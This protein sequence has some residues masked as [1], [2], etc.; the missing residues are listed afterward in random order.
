MLTTLKTYKRLLVFAKPYKTR[1]IIGIVCGILAGG[2]LFGA[3]RFI[4]PVFKPFEKEV[5][6][7]T[8]VQTEEGATEEEEDSFLDS[9]VDT[10]AAKFNIEKAKEDGT[11]TWQFMLLSILGLPL[12]IG[13]R[14]VMTFLNRY[15]MRW[16][17][18]RIIMDIR[19]KLFENLGR[20]SLKYFSL[21]DV[22]GLISRCTYD[23]QMVEGAVSRSIADLTRAPIEIFAAAL[24]IVVTAIQYGI[25]G[26]LFVFLIL[27]P[28]ILLP[29][30]VLSRRIKRHTSLALQGISRLVSRMQETFTGIK[31]IKAFNTEKTELERFK[32]LNFN[33][34]KDMIRALRAELF[35]QPWSEVIG[36]V[37]A[38]LGLVYCF[39]KDINLYQVAPLA[40]AVLFA[41]RPFKQLIK[42]NATVQRSAAAAERLYEILDAD[43]SLPEPK[44]AVDK[45]SFDDKI[46]FDNVSFRYSSSQPAVL[47]DVNFELSKGK[48]A[49]FVG[50][51][52]AGKSTI[53]N[54][55]ARFYDPTDGRITM[56]GTDLRNIRISSL[57]KLVGI[58]TQE[59]ILFN[60]SIANNIAYGSPNA[61]RE[62]VIQAAKEANADNFIRSHP[63]GYDRGIGDRGMMLSGGQ[64]QRLAIARAILR[65]PPILILDEAT[66]ALD[67]VTE[68]LVQEALFR[69]MANRTVFAIAHRLSTIKHADQIY[70]LEEGCIK[71]RGTHD[72]LYRAEGQYRE[73]CDLQFS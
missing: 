64:Q 66:S 48:V 54:L 12:F 51:T 40:G 10:L 67:T 17:G 5:S 62:D 9:T 70:L 72:E 4:G 33:Y 2:S 27:V 23:T 1:L 55:L 57:R 13:L 35:M 58:V 6:P 61:S 24:F 32:K 39:A 68:K 28:A 11:I 8:M 31:I 53:A 73:L 63:D 38:C 29:L 34:F 16:V 45:Q 20:Q 14:A 18:A 41:Y 19:N 30:S 21:S 43:T 15:F 7:D 26:S 25:V 71:E 44:D 42:V 36:I 69:L 65:D 60:D 46:I 50:E 56:D 52:G 59:T 3:L 49:A 47:Q 22:G 37:F